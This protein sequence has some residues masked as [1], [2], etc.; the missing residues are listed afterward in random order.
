MLQPE[1]HASQV[2]AAALHPLLHPVAALHCAV[3]AG[4]WHWAGSE[5]GD[6]ALEPDV[7][8][9]CA[10]DVPTLEMLAATTSEE[11]ASDLACQALAISMGERSFS[12]TPNM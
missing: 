2:E 3:G 6:E 7:V 11:A 5:H 12:P 9:A 8:M 10:G 1:V 4:I